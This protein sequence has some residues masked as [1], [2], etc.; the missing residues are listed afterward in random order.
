MWHDGCS[1]EAAKRLEQVLERFGEDRAEAL[2]ELQSA[3]EDA[4]DNAR[5]LELGADH[6]EPLESN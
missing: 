4:I 1:A 2:G 5:R 3:M 6:V